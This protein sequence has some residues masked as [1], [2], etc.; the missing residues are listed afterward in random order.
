VCQI[1]SRSLGRGDD[2]D[3][4]TALAIA[5]LILVPAGLASVFVPLLDHGR[6]RLLFSIAASNEVVALGVVLA[7]D[8]YLNFE[9]MLATVGDVAL[10]PVRVDVVAD[11]CVDDQPPLV[12]ESA[13]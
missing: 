10:Q 11:L 5:V 7:Q 12:D 9:V 3:G 8:M 4:N 6:G 2:T 1:F 13:G